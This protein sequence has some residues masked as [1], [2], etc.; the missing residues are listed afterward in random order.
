MHNAGVKESAK[1]RGT[2]IMSGARVHQS[3]SQASGR[4]VAGAAA[5]TGGKIKHSQ[6]NTAPQYQF[7]LGIVFF[8]NLACKSR[9]LAYG[10]SR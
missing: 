7:G 1:R 3:S 6:P 5:F 9:V 8:V 4:G 2:A 10:L